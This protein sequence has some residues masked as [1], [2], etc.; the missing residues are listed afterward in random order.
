MTNL[1]NR[2][3]EEQINVRTGFLPLPKRFQE[4]ITEFKAEFAKQK[5]EENKP[6]EAL[7]RIL[8]IKERIIEL[9]TENGGSQELLD[10]LD[11]PNLPLE[12][13]YSIISKFVQPN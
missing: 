10:L 7:E 4:I 5:E 3:E 9:L 2:I 12:Y 8:E 13:S 11:N 1:S 6:Q